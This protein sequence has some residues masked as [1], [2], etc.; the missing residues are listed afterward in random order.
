VKFLEHRKQSDAIIL[1]RPVKLSRKYVPLS[2]RRDAPLFQSA[3]DL[4][5][6]L[7]GALGCVFQRFAAEVELRLVRQFHLLISTAAQSTVTG[8]GDAIIECRWRRQ[9]SRIGFMSGSRRK[10]N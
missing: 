6:K 7:A 5:K 4:D 2:R 10:L 9:I 8:S 3:I 1:E